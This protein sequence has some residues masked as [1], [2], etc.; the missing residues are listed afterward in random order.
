MILYQLVSTMAI[1][2]RQNN[3]VK[4]V[5]IFMICPP[6]SPSSLTHSYFKMH[7]LYLIF[8]IYKIRLLRMHKVK[9]KKQRE[10]SA[11]IY[12]HIHLHNLNFK[13]SIAQSCSDYKINKEKKR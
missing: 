11:H 7:K 8:Y 5:I 1:Y 9:A 13:V 10:S 3:S 4:C 12:E 2:Q 6:L